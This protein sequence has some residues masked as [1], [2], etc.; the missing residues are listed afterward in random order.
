MSLRAKPKKQSSCPVAVDFVFSCG[1]TGC[2]NLIRFRKT[3]GPGKALDLAREAGWGHVPDENCIPFGVM[4]CPAHARRYEFRERA[5]INAMLE[6]KCNQ[7]ET[8][9]TEHV[10]WY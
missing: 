10:A 4:L 3:R 2:T 5:R 9:D 7:P 6:A 8:H 1:E